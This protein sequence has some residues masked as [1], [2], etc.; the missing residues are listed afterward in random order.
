MS[1]GR[2][3]LGLCASDVNLSNKDAFKKKFKELTDANRLVEFPKVYALFDCAIPHSLEKKDIN[4]VLI[5]LL[6]TNKNANLDTDNVISQRLDEKTIVLKNNLVKPI[7]KNV[8]MKKFSQNLRKSTFMKNLLSKNCT[9]SSLSF[10]TLRPLHQ[11]WLQY[12][13][14]LKESVS[15]NSELQKQLA[16]LDLHGAIVEVRICRRSSLV[17]V[18]GIVAAVSTSGIVII[19]EANNRRIRI[20]MEGTTLQYK[21]GNVLVTR[22]S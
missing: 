19:R 5:S 22:S 11:R 14:S 17:G 16:S 8:M 1:L 7:H 4:D 9:S 2:P 20:P 6:Q 13:A 10:E 21:F 3:Q 15:S 12:A 18:S